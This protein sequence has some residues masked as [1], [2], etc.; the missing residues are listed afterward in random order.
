MGDGSTRR[1][2][3]PGA[4][5]R[6][7]AVLGAV[8][9]SMLLVAPAY[10]AD[11]TLHLSKSQAASGDKVPFTISNTGA[12]A[13]YTLKIGDQEVKTGTDDGTGIKDDFTMPDLGS[14]ART[15]SVE[16]DVIQGST[17]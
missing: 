8:A 11:P 14:N 9:V 12:G 15:V 2:D 3:G 5:R 17:E 7:V 1:G 4:M 13:S 16:A 6:C 10:A